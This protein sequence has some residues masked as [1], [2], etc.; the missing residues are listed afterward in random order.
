MAML[1]KQAISEKIHARLH[2]KER[3]FSR[4]QGEI[5]PLPQE[6]FYSPPC[7]MKD[8][9][10]VVQKKK[11]VHVPDVLPDAQSVLHEMIQLIEIHIGEKLAREIADGDSL[12]ESILTTPDDLAAERERTLIAYL[13]SEKADKNLMIDV[14]EEFGNVAGE[15]ETRVR[16]PIAQAAQRR[17]RPLAASARV[18]FEDESALEN[19]L[20]PRDERVVYDA[21]AKRRGLYLATFGIV[22][23]EFA[24]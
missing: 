23:D 22:D 12:A 5:K 3:C 16:L 11:V 9:F 1:F 15:D 24:I 20:D 2:R 17:V 14:G 19:R 7:I 4:M 6:N 18:A 13:F 10:V 8:A 21:V